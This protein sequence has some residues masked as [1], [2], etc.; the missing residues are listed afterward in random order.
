MGNYKPVKVLIVADSRHAGDEFLKALDQHE[1]LA[2]NVPTGEKALERIWEEAPGFILLSL[3]LAGMS[4]LDVLRIV[5]GDSRSRSIPIITFSDKPEQGKIL[6][7]FNLEIDDYIAKPFHHEELAARIKAVLNR[8]RPTSYNKDDVLAKG[9]IKVI[10]SSHRVLCE[11]KEVDMTPKEYELLTLLLRK[12]GRVLSREY[13]LES[14]WGWSKDVNTRT[15]DM[16][17]A[18][19]RKKLKKE[20]SKWIETVQGYGYTIPNA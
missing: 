8:R 12:E 9:K 19:L 4:G 5:R 7:A 15:V 10:P 18:R 2:E 3:E 16:L 14:L 11:E 6:A 20:G 13:L 1:F 17:V